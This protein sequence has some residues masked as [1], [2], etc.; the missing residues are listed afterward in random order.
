[1]LDTPISSFF[2]KSLS[3]GFEIRKSAYTSWTLEKA[4]L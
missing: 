2:G 1:M 4:V 3:W